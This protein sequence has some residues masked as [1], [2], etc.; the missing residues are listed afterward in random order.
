VQDLNDKGLGS[1]LTHD[2]WNEMPTELQNIITA[3]GIALSALDLDQLG[4]AVAGYAGSA[5]YYNDSGIADAYVLGVPGSK[6]GIPTLDGDVD[7]LFVRFRP[8]NDNTGASTVVVNGILPGA[9]KDIKR[10]DGT[11]LVAGDLV[12]TKDAILRWDN[13]TG[14]FF[15]MDYA[16]P[17]ATEATG[18]LVAKLVRVSNTQVK[19][20]RALASNILVE[21]DGVILSQGGD[22]TFDITTD[23]ESGHSEDASTPYYLYAYNSSGTMIPKLSKTPPVFSSG[24]VGYHPGTGSGSNTWR[25]VGSWWN[26]ASSNFADGLLSNG[27]FMFGQNESD[28]RYALNTSAP[29]GWYQRDM[30]IPDGATSVKLAAEGVATSAGVVFGAGNASG[31]PP[32][33]AGAKHFDDTGMD[34]V[35]VIAPYCIGTNEGFAIEFELPIDDLSD[36]DIRYANVGTGTVTENHLKILGYFDPYAPRY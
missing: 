20:T 7:G 29:A 16:R 10:E 24:K 36:P 22:L 8:G 34:G 19:L 28:Q 2:E 30:D 26:N 3:F 23:R 35:L 33:S 9:P 18:L 31:T 32:V 1:Q 4:K 27:Y 12:T 5:H 25:C 11:A 14:D 15:L 6:Q 17:V 21:I 13:S